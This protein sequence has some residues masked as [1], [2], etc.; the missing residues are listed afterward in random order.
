MH[1]A[2]FQ[3]ALLFLIGNR[4]SSI[5]R[6]WPLLST[7]GI[8]LA[9]SQVAVLVLIIIGNRPSRITSSPVP[10]H[11]KSRSYR[12][13]WLFSSGPHWITIRT[14]E[15][16]ILYFSTWVPNFVASQY[17]SICSTW[18]TELVASQET[19][20]VTVGP[21]CIAAMPECTVFCLMIA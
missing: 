21:H 12:M 3:G 2:T 19:F 10:V 13:P 18:G 15:V 11:T 4:P 6:G 14:F 9:A 5:L 8:D 16:I 17:I 7:L 20:C 1:T